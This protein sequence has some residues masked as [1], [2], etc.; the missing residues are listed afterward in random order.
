MVAIKQK[1][2]YL[3][4]GSVD[5]NAW[6]QKISK[7]YQFKEFTILDNVS[8]FVDASCKGLTTPYG[9]PCIEQSLEMAEILLDLTHDQEAT[10]AA[11]LVSAVN[12][13]QANIEQIKNQ[14]G[15]P[16][17][18]L[19][20]GISHMNIV[21]KLANAKTRDQ[22]QIDRLRKALLALVSDIRV[23]L[24]KLAERTCLMRGIKNINLLERKRIAQ[25]T[26]DLYAPLANRLGIGQLKWELEDLSFH[27]I[28]PEAYKAIAAFLAERRVD[29]ENRIH[30]VIAR[31]KE[32][33]HHAHIQADISGRAK[34]IYSIFLKMK[35]KDLDY[36]H[37]YDASAVRV[38][39][40]TI[41]D[42]YK[43]LSIIHHEWEH[44]ND[45]F[46]DYISNPKPN[47]YRSVHTA[48]VDQ[49]GKNIEIQIRTRTMHNEAEHGFAAHWI[50]KEDKSHP[51]GYESKITFLRQL[52]A[53][54]KEVAKDETTVDKLN[55]QIFEDRIYVFTPMGDILDLPIGSTPLDFAYQVHSNLGHRCR[56][57]KINGHI[58][59]LTYTL[60]TG[61]QVDII[62]IKE[63]SPSRD[64][65]SKDAGYIKTSRA[66]AKIA[67]W[68]R[69]QDV[70]QYIDSGK[71]TLEKEFAR[72]GIHQPN[73]QKIAALFNYKEDDALFAAIGHGIIKPAQVVHAAQTEHHKTQESTTHL[74]IKKSLTSATHFQVAGTQDLLTRI[75]RCCKPIPGDDIVGYIT[76]G[77]G[78]S[79]HR[80]TCS[81]MASLLEKHEGRLIDVNWNPQELGSYLVD[82]QIRARAKD[83][84]IKEITT[85][86]PNHKIDLI[87]L[88]SSMSQK[89]NMLYITMTIQINNLTQLH[90]LMT[91][92]QHIPHLID[93]KRVRE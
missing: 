92:L 12:H 16:I 39:V 1:L 73:L 26:M 4:D 79:I 34:H 9:Q 13:S 49:H 44:I 35:R 20:S 56:G 82:L 33:L 74:T 38:L 83:D 42:C 67:Q 24:I 53:W 55:E 32:Q 69:Q 11:M 21:S 76:Q 57:A 58:V 72:A 40:P 87:S 48:V 23:V 89:N 17:A 3:A 41:E 14:F 85:L 22:S 46:D 30:A 81:N 65:L 18:K 31:L 47:G 27:Y 7:Q 63:G 66:R 71:H 60:Q 54:H 59:P 2:T 68:F 50:Y 52:L 75:A 51:S 77:R 37:I 25:E 88:N 84:M 6:L 43:A 8:H 10:A 90:Q 45:E 78:I 93:V 91:A 15:E 29:R 62:T 5:L 70:T 19:V 36:Q 61:D 28:D 86:L 64:W 80:K